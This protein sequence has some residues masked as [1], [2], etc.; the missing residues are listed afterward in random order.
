[1]EED[2]D[3]IHDKHKHKDEN[4]P[5]E[6]NEGIRQS[7]QTAPSPPLNKATVT[8]THSRNQTHSQTQPHA[9]SASVSI[10]EGNPRIETQD[11]VGEKP[12]ETPQTSADAA[13][14]KLAE[15]EAAE[16][17]GSEASKEEGTSTTKRKRK[18]KRKDF[19]NFKP[20]FRKSTRTASREDTTM[21]SL[22]QLARSVLTGRKVVFLTGAGLSVASGIP[23]FRG[24]T[25]AVWTQVSWR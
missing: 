23:P 18:R 17:G 14:S 4:K 10:P 21:S 1:M 6:N 15:G 13:E 2:K 16:N 19:K 12:Q 22:G 25:D 11:S 20:G 8:Q 3:N 24:A 9:A 7:E 5:S